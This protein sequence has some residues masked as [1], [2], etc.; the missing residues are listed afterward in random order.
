MQD[1]RDAHEVQLSGILD[2]PVDPDVPGVLVTSSEVQ[3]LIFLQPL[4]VGPSHGLVFQ[5]QHLSLHTFSFH[6]RTGGFLRR[7]VSGQG[8][9]GAHPRP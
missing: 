8:L 7:R 9:M 4:R 6:I 5:S 1:S 2:A 3:M